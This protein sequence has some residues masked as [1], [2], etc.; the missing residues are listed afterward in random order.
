MELH[1]SEF[2]MLCLQLVY[3]CVRE[4]PR[5]QQLDNINQ[6]LTDVDPENLYHVFCA[7]IAKEYKE[8]E[9]VMSI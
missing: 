9:L 5:K 7:K 3:S 4:L 1:G 6:I 2:Y 8:Q